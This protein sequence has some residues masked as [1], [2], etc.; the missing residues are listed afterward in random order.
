MPFVVPEFPL[1]CDVY[2]G[3][4]TTKVLRLAGVPC[5]LAWSKR[6]QPGFSY[7]GT[8]ASSIPQAPMTLLLPAL[9]DLRDGAGLV[10][11]EPDVVEVP[12]GSGRWYAVEYVDDIG[13]GFPN[14]HRAALIYKIFEKISPA[15]FPGLVWPVP[16]P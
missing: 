3:P 8:P 14:E 10:G 4:W 16:I 15:Q 1:T 12:A 2:N 9:T 6:I 13:K 5:N 7:G 11:A